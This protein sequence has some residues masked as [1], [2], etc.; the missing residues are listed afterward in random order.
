MKHFTSNPSVRKILVNSQ[1]AYQHARIST[2][3]FMSQVLHE[4]ST[5]SWQIINSYAVIGNCKRTDYRL[6][7]ILENKAVTLSHK[8]VAEARNILMKEFV[9]VFVTAIEIL[10]G[11]NLIVSK[12]TKYAI[13]L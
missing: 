2:E 4:V 5:T 10:T 12:L 6:R 9:K 13:I 3:M 11:D 1:T 8:V 7:I